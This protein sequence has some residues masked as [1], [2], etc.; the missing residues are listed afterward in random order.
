VFREQQFSWVV[1]ENHP[2]ISIPTTQDK[3]KSCQNSWR[4]RAG[5]FFPYRTGT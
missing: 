5:L 3:I 2:Y 4:V 1:P